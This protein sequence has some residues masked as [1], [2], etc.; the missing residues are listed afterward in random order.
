[1]MVI[2]K[3]ANTMITGMKQPIHDIADAPHSLKIKN[4]A[5]RGR[6]TILFICVTKYT[7]LITALSFFIHILPNGVS[8]R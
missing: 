8:A 6:H 7:M 3:I 2:G 5:E 4:I 1:M